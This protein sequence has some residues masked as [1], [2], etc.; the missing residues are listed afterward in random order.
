MTIALFCLT[1]PSFF[2]VYMHATLPMADACATCRNVSECLFSS[3][4]VSLFSNISYVLEP[5]ILINI[6]ES[7]TQ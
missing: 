6:S 1:L 3:G 4:A 5:Q 7:R 2:G